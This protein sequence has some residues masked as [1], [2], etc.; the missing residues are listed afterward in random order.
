MPL[1]YADKLEYAFNHYTTNWNALYQCRS[2]W[3]IYIVRVHLS[4]PS[5]YQDAEGRERNESTD[6]VLIVKQLNIYTLS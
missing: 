3:Q 4:V 6:S 2:T 5:R 1:S